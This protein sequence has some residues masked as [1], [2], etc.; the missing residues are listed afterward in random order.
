MI[1]R[2]KPIKRSPIRRRRTTR[3][4]AKT[5]LRKKIRLAV[6]ERAGGMCEL[7]LRDDCLKG[8]L[9]FEG[10][11]V[12]RTFYDHGHLV[13]MKS[14]GAG[15]KTDLEN[16]RWGCWRCHLLGLHNGETRDAKPVPAKQ[17]LRKDWISD[18]YGN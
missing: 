9:P 10:S 3:S 5:D 4:K 17:L 13:H 15:G 7:K 8:P 2:Q 1:P 14:E 11:K 18:Y 6:F 12:D 16:C